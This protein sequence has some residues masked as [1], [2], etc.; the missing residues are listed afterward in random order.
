ARVSDRAA[1]RT[2]QRESACPQSGHSVSGAAQAGADGVDFVQMGRLRERPSR[3]DLRPDAR[4]AQAA[5]QRGGAVA[6][7]GEYRRTLPEDLGEPLMTRLR[8]FL[9]RLS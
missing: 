8:I 7:C 4:R 2:D 6:A 9:F 5:P 3:E 1:N